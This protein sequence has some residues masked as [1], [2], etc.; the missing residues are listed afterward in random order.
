MRLGCVSIGA[1]AF[2]LAALSP[3]RP[4]AADFIQKP[5]QDDSKSVIPLDFSRIRT[6]YLPEASTVQIEIHPFAGSMQSPP[7]NGSAIDPAPLALPAVTPDSSGTDSAPHAMVAQVHPLFLQPP[8]GSVPEPSFLG[9]AG[10]L[11][12]SLLLYRPRRGFTT[13]GN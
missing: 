8:S 5:H 13:T 11:G 10:L 7:A 9:V 2:V 3:L 12:V 6:G 1:L 4:V